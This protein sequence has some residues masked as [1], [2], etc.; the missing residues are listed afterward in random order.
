MNG[1]YTIRDIAAITGF[2]FKTVSRVINDEPNVKP[3]TK[4]KILQAIAETGYKPNIYARSLNG[5]S[6]RNLLVSIRKTHGQ[7]TTQWFDYFMSHLIRESQ[8]HRYTII[9]EVV[10]D[11]EDLERSM[12]EQSSGYIDAVVL[13]Y[14]GD[15]DKRI[16]QARSGGVPFV[17]FEKHPLAPVSISNNNRKGMRE[18]AR[19]LFDRGLT[20]ICLLLGAEI[21][22]N[23]EREAAMQ[24]A[25]RERGVPL[26][27]LEV[28]YRMNNLDNIKRY[29]EGRIEAGRLPEAFF[30]S[31]DE[32][33]IAV[34]S[35][36]YGKGLSI[37]GDVSVIGFD[38]I[39]ISSYYYP[40]LTT[41][42]QNFEALASEM[43][44]VIDRM[45]AGDT[46]VT[47]VQVDPELIVRG[48]VK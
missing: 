13:F 11:D 22:V 21:D 1:K 9:Q 42:G 28:A 44:Q 17:S 12:L 36:V 20:N 7:N 47:S 6:I 24:E 46:D 35:A 8:R 16:E 3:S 41:M 5:K 19:F 33:A 23:L 26:D 2:S 10:Y 45:L 48:S 29:V 4:E 43:V 34:Y 25:Y 32:K 18:A 31:G 27:R 40:P 37:P 15:N 38:N 30:V 39:P 14:V